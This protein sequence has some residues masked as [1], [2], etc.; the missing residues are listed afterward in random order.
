[1]NDIANDAE[2]DAFNV[3]IAAATGDAKTT[4]T[5][6]KIKNKVL[7]LTATS[8]ELQIKAAQG[9]D[10]AAKLAAETKKLNNNIALDKKAAGQPS[11]KL[12]FDATTAA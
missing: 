10:T 9:E 6:G 5:N 2:T 12:A 1:V 8:L 3:E 4:L 7:K 11:T